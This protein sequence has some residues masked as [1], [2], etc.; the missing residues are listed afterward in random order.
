MTLQISYRASNLSPSRTLSISALANKLIAQGR[1]VI[2]LSVGQPHLPMPETARSGIEDALK[3]SLTGYTA[4]GGTPS[5]KQ[6]IIEKFKRENS[7][8]YQ[9]DQ[10]LVSCGAKHSIFNLCQAILN[11]GDEVI[12]ASPYWLSY[13]EIVRLAGA[14]VRVCSAGMKQKFK[15]TPSQ[16]DE[17]I[18]PRT[19]LM[20]INSPN[21][22]SGAVYT[23]EELSA[24]AQVLLDHHNIM[25]CSDDIYEHFVYTNE[26]FCNIIN[27]CP[28]LYHRT[29]VVNGVS[30]AYSMTGLRIG[31]AA[32]ASEIITNMNKIQSQV[33]SNPCSVS[34]R[35]AEF[36]LNGEQSSRMKMK[37][38]YQE[39]RNF[40]YSVF[41][42]LKGV[43]PILP[44]GAFYVFADFREALANIPNVHDDLQ[45]SEYLLAKY[46]L[47]TVPGI[48]FGTKNHLR[49]SYSVGREKLEKAADYLRAAFPS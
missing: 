18:T 21:N 29:I 11:P 43:N 22:P 33:T 44:D 12:L 38:T 4:V 23:R 34:Q 16:L 14:K 30:K 40:F 19:R 48:T 37:E 15:I 39:H 5:L 13:P 20:M 31:Y 17:V 24:L 8:S 10:I 45:L 47:S 6:A 3:N 46:N 28:D 36:V 26:P 25:I 1:P 49:I 7:L 32:G 42:D 35:A 41:K 9:P 27:V 2:N